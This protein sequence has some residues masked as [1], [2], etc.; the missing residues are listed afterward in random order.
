MSILRSQIAGCGSY[1][2]ARIVTNA[3]LA[4]RVDTTDD[5]IV[6][7]T[8]IRQRHVAAENE[9]T[10]TLGL[11]AAQAALADAGMDAA[12]ID[13]IIVATATPDHTFPATATQI[14][15]AL[16]ISHGAAFD[17]QAVCSGFVFAL[18]TADKFLSTGAA[19]AALV[20][21]A[22]TFSRILDW[23][24][25]T[26]CVLFGDGAGAVV[27]KAAPG[28]GTLAD[29]GVLTTHIRSDGRYKDKL[30]VDGGPGSTKTV[31]FLRMEGKEVFRHAV[32]NLAETV[33]H[34]FEQTGLSGADIDWF[35]PHQA[36]RRIIDATADKLG[37]DRERVVVT[38]DRHGNTSAASI[39]MALAEAH[40]DGR[41]KR[42]QLVLIEAMGG[43][44]TWGSALIRW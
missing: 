32:Q 24:D 22:E 34:T 7:R 38:V 5:W 30:Y 15:A 42:G 35:V 16:G 11:K 18:A 6:Q 41:I 10:S 13:L 2:P 27:M 14:Q 33:R 31:G 39:P 9:A 44:F 19:K 29:R 12:E 26:T 17:L 1:L 25:R 43:G 21:G 40:H 3:E 28:D 37:I 4:Q 8:G 36:N 23:E 20:I